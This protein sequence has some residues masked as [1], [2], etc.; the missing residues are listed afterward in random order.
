M[1]RHGNRAALRA[2]RLFSG[3]WMNQKVSAGFA[4]IIIG[5]SPRSGT[6]LLAGLLNQHPRIYCGPEFGVFC[7][8]RKPKDLAAMSG[9]PVTEISAML[10]LVQL[11]LFSGKT[12]GGGRAPFP[13]STMGLF[14]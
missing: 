10:V 2:P 12:C 8:P 6:S 4:P 14:P 1:R 11:V 9:L 13:T 7:R 3:H 5:G